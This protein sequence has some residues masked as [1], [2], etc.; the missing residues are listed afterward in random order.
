MFLKETGKV[1][2]RDCVHVL[3]G[4]LP[5]FITSHICRLGH[6]LPHLPSLY[7][8]HGNLTSKWV[9]SALN[10]TNPGLFQIRFQYVL[11]RF[12]G[13]LGRLPSVTLLVE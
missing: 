12:D 10:G 5:R 6:S 3:L 1:I 2:R 13:N 4:H 7:D 9:R 8:R 11:G